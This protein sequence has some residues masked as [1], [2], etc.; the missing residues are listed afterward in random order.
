MQQNKN[1]F[2]ICDPEIDYAVS[3][4]EFLNR[5]RNLLFEVQAFTSVELLCEYAAEHP[6]EIL[7]ISDKVMCPAVRNLPVTRLLILSEGMHSP[8]L[9]QYPSVYKYQASADVVREVMD[10]YGAEKEAGTMEQVWKRSVEI[11]GIY[12]PVGRVRKTSF[13]LTLGQILA[14]QRPVLYLNMESYS[15]FEEMMGELYERNISDLLYFLRQEDGNLVHRM[16][17]MVRSLQQLDFIPPALSP[18]DIQYSP[19]QD[20]LRLLEEIVRCSSYEVLI[21]DLGDALQDLFQIMDY[22]TR[23]YCPVRND[24]ISL[25]KVSHFENLLEMWNYEGVKAKLQKVQVPYINSSRTG[26]AYFEDLVWT[27]VGDYVR[28]LLKEEKHEVL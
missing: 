13:A 27:P 28:E 18:M 20:W 3:F 4:M 10:C 21:L 17:G 12:S 8:A 5:R 25:A 23:I 19:G 1:V 9:D 26:R 22:C 16:N 11:I 14:E 6:I 2:A 15:G 24:A 7:L